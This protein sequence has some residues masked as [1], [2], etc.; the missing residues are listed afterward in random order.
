MRANSVAI[1]ERCS[2]NFMK[3]FTLIE[4]LVVI[5]IIS[6]LAALSLPAVTGAL[7]KGQITQTVSN[8]RQLSLLTQ[9]A[10]FDLQTAG[11]AGAFP[12]DIGNSFTNWSNAVVPSYCSIQTFKN[13]LMVK[14]TSSN[15]TIYNVGS[16][17]DSATVF[18]ATANVSSNGVAN[19]APYNNK[20]GAVVTVGGQALLIT[21]TN[22]LILSNNGVSWTSTV[23]P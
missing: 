3:G 19:V 16:S 4:L 9:S 7:T 20:G 21:G 17:S 11:G 18:L 2:G 23:G 1:I 10:S 5:S 14:G 8:Y 22:M 12:G 6:V 15:T 13:L